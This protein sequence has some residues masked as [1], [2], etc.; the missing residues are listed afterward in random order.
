M[1]LIWEKCLFFIS[2]SFFPLFFIYFLPNSDPNTS[3]WPKPYFEPK[4]Q[5]VLPQPTVVTPVPPQPL[6]TWESVDPEDDTS[7][8]PAISSE[9]AVS[10]TEASDAYDQMPPVPAT[11]ESLPG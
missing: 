2:Q 7:L 10:G 11:E 5:A 9:S 3:P 4:A 1:V 8:Q 6:S